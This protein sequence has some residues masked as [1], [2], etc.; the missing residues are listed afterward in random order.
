[1]KNGAALLSGLLLAALFCS[2][3]TESG[4]PVDTSNPDSEAPDIPVEIDGA[5]WFS[6][7]HANLAADRSGTRSR[8]DVCSMINGKFSPPLKLSPPAGTEAD[9]ADCAF[10]LSKLD[11]A[12]NNRT[13][14]RSSRYAT[15]DLVKSDTLAAALDFLFSDKKF[16]VLSPSY[17]SNLM[18]SADGNAWYPAAI[19][20]AGIWREIAAGGGKFAALASGAGT[21]RRAAYS[22]DGINWTGAT[23]PF[24]ASWEGLSFGG[25]SFVAV[26][27][28]SNK[29]AYST[30][31]I[32]WT[33]TDMPIGASW[34][35][36]AYGDGTFAAVATNNSSMA[37]YSTD[38]ITWT[39]AEL[40]AAQNWNAL[41]YGNGIFTALAL[42]SG[43]AAYS[44][45]GGKTWSETA[46]PAAEWQ[47]LAFG[48]GRFIAVAAGRAI[49]STN[50][51]DWTETTAG[52]SG[53]N[54]RA[55]AFGKGAFM[56]VAR[57][58]IA[59]ST[60]G[61]NWTVASSLP[62]D[63]EWQDIVYGP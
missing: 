57:T 44:T 6:L 37:A 61:L 56:A 36:A 14:Y 45:D 19:P 16:A 28:Y 22:T 23:L 58:S 17:G 31:G 49:C 46:I 5:L 47:D 62:L 60:D 63:A 42:N 59:L 40:P 8:A 2:C 18:V 33:E 3:R 54:W 11:E 43:T 55:A 32:E 50:G 13:R 34:R 41:A 24:D 4:G 20:L 10:F 38:G 12:N 52:L 9:P 1:M 48:N 7:A 51:V 26:A 35:A 53:E 30:D 39:G 29:A 15:E 21:R 25:G 27:S